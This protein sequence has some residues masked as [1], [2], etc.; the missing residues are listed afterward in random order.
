MPLNMN[1]V[2]TGNGIGGAT[3]SPVFT[4]EP[5]IGE[6]L[7]KSFS[8]VNVDMNS[9]VLQKEITKSYGTNISLT[10]PQIYF[11]GEYYGYDYYYNTY[12][13]NLYKL[14]LNQDGSITRTSIYSCYLIQDNSVFVCGDY[15]WFID[16]NNNLF[17]YDG[18]TVV[19]IMTIP[20]MYT[21]S[22]PMSRYMSIV[23]MNDMCTKVIVLQTFGDMGSWYIDYGG[24]SIM[25]ISP[26][27]YILNPTFTIDPNNGT[28]PNKILSSSHTYI[29]FITE[30]KYVEAVLSQSKSS[31][32]G[33]ITWKEY[34]IS[35][36]KTDVE[37]GVAYPCTRTLVKTIIATKTF[38]Q[39]AISLSPCTV[40]GNNGNTLL[41]VNTLYSNNDNSSVT[42]L[43]AIYEISI[44]SDSTYKI[45][46]KQ[47]SSSIYQKFLLRDAPYNIEAVC[48]ACRIVDEH[49][50]LYTV[51]YGGNTSSKLT[52]AWSTIEL[53]CKYSSVNDNSYCIFTGLLS[54][55]DKILTAT[56]ITNIKNT[57]DINMDINCRS[58]VIPYDGTYSFNVLT[59]EDTNIPPFII[60]TPEGSLLNTKLTIDTHANNDYANLIAGMKVNKN[61]IDTS[62]NQIITSFKKNNRYVITL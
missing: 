46:F 13:T 41:G 24:Y 43:E 14:V 38:E 9:V 19:K 2:G 62:G 3:S 15:M 10:L 26:D 27:G 17:R 28:T 53:T 35:F 44:N 25:E 50:Y 58:Y 54:K 42:S 30:T 34:N 4:T 51:A 31:Y 59:L 18:T 57:N 55:G 60:Q 47:F 36:K 1:T 6:E 40:I 49:W 61:V 32:K 33:Q 23:P 45:T 21:S 16:A 11:K 8:S 20:Q 5:N 7:H 56:D 52:G 39:G 12:S 37:N 48:M 22:P 29:K